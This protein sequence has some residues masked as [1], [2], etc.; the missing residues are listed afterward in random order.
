MSKLFGVLGVSLCV[1]LAASH[2]TAQDADE[3]AKLKREIELLKRENEVLKKE[4]EQLKAGGAKAQPSA[5]PKTLADLLPEGTIIVGDYRF[6]AGNKATGDW[7][8]TIKEL[9]G[10]KFKGTYT[11]KETSP[12]KFEIPQ[13][14]V[15]G[16]IDGNRLKF[17][18]VN[19]AKIQASVSGTLKKGTIE[20]VW[21]ERGSIADMKAKAPK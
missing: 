3:V 21:N 15:E 14:D 6:R 1:L 17:T 4:N 20:L 10:K 5:K 13:F 8:L 9:E 12:N 11:A 7:W 2:A 19:T 16:E 18:F